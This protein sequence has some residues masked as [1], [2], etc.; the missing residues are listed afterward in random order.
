MTFK[1][2]KNNFNRNDNNKLKIQ[3]SYQNN[4]LGMVIEKLVTLYLT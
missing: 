4:C 1:K 3:D 2:L